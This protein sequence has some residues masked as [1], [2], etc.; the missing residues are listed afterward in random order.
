MRQDDANPTRHFQ[1]DRF[2]A[3]GD[4]WYF[5]TREGEQLGPFESK[6]KAESKLRN[7]LATQ[8]TI[9]RIRKHDPALN[10]SSRDNA[11]KIAELYSDLQKNRQDEC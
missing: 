11:K 6:A 10:D 1:S 7:Y 8:A 3:V 5:L 2:F 4:Q 9:Q